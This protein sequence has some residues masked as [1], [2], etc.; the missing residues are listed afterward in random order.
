MR[1]KWT[2]WSLAAMMAIL[3]LALTA[4]MPGQGIEDKRP[5][6]PLLHDY[7]S[8]TVTV[9]GSPAPSGTQLIACVD[10]CGTYRSD[11]VSVG[12]NGAFTGLIL[13]PTDRRMI[14]RDVTFHIVNEHGSIQADQ[15]GEFIGVYDLYSSGLTF[16]HPPPLPGADAHPHADSQRPTPQPTPTPEPTHSHPGA[17]GH[18]GAHA[19]PGA[20]GHAGTH[21]N[22]HAGAD[23][24]AGTHGH[25]G[26]DGHAGTHADGHPARNRRPGG[27]GA[28]I[29]PLAIAGGVAL[30]IVGLCALYLAARRSR[31][32]R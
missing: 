21:A 18:P 31:R 6:Q 8:G 9:Q 23:G 32:A 22:G 27:D 11:P 29:P 17:D 2:A 26:A 7:Y 28:R 25:A 15:T 30:A 14:G 5:A 12:G 10:G 24:Y 20:D 1:A 4:A 3:A 16:S 13:D 19:D